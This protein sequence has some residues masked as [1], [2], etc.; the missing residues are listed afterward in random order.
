MKNKLLALF[1]LLLVISPFNAGSINYR[2][3]HLAL[4][5]FNVTISPQMMVHLT[6]LESSFPEVK[7]HKTNKI[8]KRIKD[9]TWILLEDRLEREIGLYLYPV[10]IYGNQFDYDEYEF[11]NTSINKAIRRGN[12]KFY[13]RVDLNIEFENVSTPTGYGSTPRQR[14]DTSST[15]TEEPLP[16]PKPR[17]VFNITTYSEKGV[18]PVDKFLGQAKGNEHWVFDSNFLNGLVN[19]QFSED[20]KT[21][22]GLMNQAISNL[23]LNMSK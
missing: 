17:I 3:K 19:D 1:L 23:I 13:L 22:M 5:A 10:N 16:E 4:I 15:A 11:P 18:I 8:I 20:P 7:N 2:N 21:F 6:S 12:S 14:R 9:I